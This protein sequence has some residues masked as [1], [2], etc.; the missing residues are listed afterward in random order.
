MVNVSRFTERTMIVELQRGAS[1]SMLDS[2]KDAQIEAL[3]DSGEDRAEAIAYVN[4]LCNRYI[5]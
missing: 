5:D 2:V 1:L 4:D 3:T